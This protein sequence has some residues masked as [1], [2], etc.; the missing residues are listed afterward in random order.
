MSCC[1][2][3]FQA[4]EDF[5]AVASLILL[6]RKH[7][8]ATAGGPDR[9]DVEDDE[10][11]EQ[12]WG[13]LPLE[14]VVY[15][16]ERF[17]PRT[18]PSFRWRPSAPTLQYNDEPPHHLVAA[19][20]DDYS[21]RSGYLNR[22]TRE[23]LRRTRPNYVEVLVEQGRGR[24]LCFGIAERSV[25]ASSI[26]IG[27]VGA[28]WR[29]WGWV[30]RGLLYFN[31]PGRLVPGPELVTGESAWAYRQ[32]DRVGI[33]VDLQRGRLAFFLNGRQ[34]APAHDDPDLQ[35]CLE[36]LHPAVS[37]GGRGYKMVLQQRLEIPALAGGE[38]ELGLLESRAALSSVEHTDLEAPTSL[39]SQD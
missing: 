39:Q 4:Q 37:F 3:S 15:M 12:L 36:P 26:P 24:S 34:I 9:V 28:K 1:P 5:L 33:Y 14:V 16:F 7:G 6:A 8:I 21:Q 22:I 2:L 30:S 10:G 31:Q 17:L 18:P 23:P 29:S 20:S 25:E 35:S 32:G 38:E 19:S 27:G 13:R 11:G